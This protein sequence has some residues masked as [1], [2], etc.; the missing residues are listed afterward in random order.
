MGKRRNDGRDR[1]GPDHDR[2]HKRPRSLIP[3]LR[4]LNGEYWPLSA[5]PPPLRQASHVDPF[6]R[7]RRADQRGESPRAVGDG[8][9]GRR[10]RRGRLAPRARVL[11]RRGHARRPL[12]SRGGRGRAGRVSS[13]SQA[14]L[15]RQRDQPGRRQARRA[16]RHGPLRR[17]GPRGR[18][19]GA[20]RRH[21]QHVPRRRTP[22]RARSGGHATHRGE[23]PQARAPSSTCA[24][25][26]TTPARPRA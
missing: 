3:C 25:A 7:R 11:G 6:H 22:A 2:N 5:E 16:D 1:G 21:G 13:R 19:A 8:R 23:L 24:P 17:P 20:P 26:S 15:D 9:S 12:P 14:G 4:A 18:W 10:R